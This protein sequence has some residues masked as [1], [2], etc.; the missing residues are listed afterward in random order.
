MATKEIQVSFE[1]TK[2][3]YTNWVLHP[4]SDKA[5]KDERTLSIINYI[6]LLISLAV[7]VTSII[8]KCYTMIFFGA[9]VL[10]VFV[11]RQFVRKRMLA[12]KYFKR[13]LQNQKTDTWIRT[14]SFASNGKIDIKDSN[15]VTSYNDDD[16]IKCE[17]DADHVYVVMKNNSV[18]RLPKDKFT[19]GTPEELLERY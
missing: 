13:A 3:I 1:I 18:I 4:I 5:K 15:V 12:S 11:Y 9:V 14:V 2:E 10:L 17:Q 19:K 6:G 16:V 7:I 8:S